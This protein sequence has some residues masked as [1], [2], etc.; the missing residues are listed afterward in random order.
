MPP[1]VAID[2]K[3][4]TNATDGDI[5]PKWPA[6]RRYDSRV[7]QPRRLPLILD[8]DA[9]IDDAMALLYAAASP[10]A[11]LIAVTCV[12]GNVSA[13]QVAENTLR[14]LELAGRGD[15]E[16][17][18]GRESP[19]LR[20]LRTA[21]DTHGPKGIGYAELPPA[22]A[23]LSARA[24]WDLIA[25][26]ARRRPGEL[27]LITLGPQ[28][29]LAAALQVEPRLPRLLRRLYVM[30]GA[31]RV[32]GNTTP[33][34]EWNMQVDPEAA[35]MVYRAWA[36]ALAADPTIPRPVVLGLDVTE[37]SPIRTD[38]IVRLARLAGSRP[39]D[40]IA[41]ARGEG[42][43]QETMSVASNPVVRFV[44]DALRFY[45]EFHAKWDGFY[46][47]HIHDPMVVAAALDPSLV[48]A[49]PVF[50]E[51]ETGSGPAGAMT[52]A[53]FR[54][55]TGKPPN[56]DVAVELDGPAFLDRWV[57]RVGALARD[58]YPPG[59]VEPQR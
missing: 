42:P 4:V 36:T 37:R 32:Q 31:F 26:E 22:R 20:P 49:E 30:G 48:R 50:V 5:R 15:V 18:L 40:A 53:D 38:E 21:E 58:L 29:N 46:G 1:R 56:V 23:A 17:A 6:A 57:Q 3:L 12:A 34:A 24:G 45:F 59:G 14:V 47:A 19:I 11:E 35:W 13:P 41:R 10:D 52:V 9:G 51:V 54:G 39:D 16:V 2:R 8:V 43:L 33:A 25:E 55:L 7:T 27:T 28:T 44:V